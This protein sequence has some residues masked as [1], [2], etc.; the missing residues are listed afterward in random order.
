MKKIEKDRLIAYKFE[1]PE[2]SKFEHGIFSRSGG[3]STGIY[4]SLNVGSTVGDDQHHV[5]E[6]KK[7]VLNFLN[8]NIDSIYD[9]WQV[10]G[11][12]VI[13]TENPRAANVPHLKAD[14]IFTNNPQVTLMM[15]F[16]DCVPI[17]LCDPVKEVVG[18]I[19]AGWIGTINNI[20]KSAIEKIREYYGCNP[21]DLVAGVGPSIGPDHYAVGDE[22]VN[23]TKRVFGDKYLE[24]LELRNGKH[25]FD[26]WKTNE[27]FLREQGIKKIEISNICTACNLQDWYSHRQEKGRTGRFGAVICIKKE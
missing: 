23:E 1:H 21:S 25:F 4:Q 7:K 22:V 13:C 27:Y 8:R 24:F 9:V 5:D 12:E 6:N 3:I 17:L 2:F 19:H 10:H 20:V 15:R 18:I 11:T 26:L 16:A 14:A